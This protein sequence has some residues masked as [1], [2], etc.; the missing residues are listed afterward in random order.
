MSRGIENSAKVAG[1][2]MIVVLGVIVC[3]ILV[4]FWGAYFEIDKIL[5]A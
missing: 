1:P 2:V 4:Q 3:L 5:A